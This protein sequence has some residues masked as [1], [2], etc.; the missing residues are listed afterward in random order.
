MSVYLKIARRILTVAAYH[1][2]VQRPSVEP[3]PASITYAGTSKR[4]KQAA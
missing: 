3:R 1:A 4:Q 2:T